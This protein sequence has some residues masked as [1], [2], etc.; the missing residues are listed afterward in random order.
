[1][2]KGVYN[3]FLRMTLKELKNEYYQCDKSDMIKKNILKKIITNKQ[4]IEKNEISK[5]K[6][7][8]SDIDEKVDNLIK[9]KEINEQKKH[10]AKIKE[11]ENLMKQRGEME[12]CWESNKTTSKIDPRYKTE[13]ETDFTNN[14]LMERLNCELDFRINDKQKSRDFIKPYDTSNNGNLIELD[15]TDVP[16]NNFSSKRLLR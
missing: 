5:E 13:V 10:L 2:D 14:K 4:E 6:K 9:L 3:K 12:K 7:I 8:K 15:D 11:F 1:M 16:V